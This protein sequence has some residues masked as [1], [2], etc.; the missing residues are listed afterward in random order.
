MF[1]LKSVIRRTPLHRCVQSFQNQQS[2][3]PSYLIDPEEVR[4]PVP[5]GEIA[6]KWWG[7]RDFRPVLA[8]HGWLDNAGTFDTLIPLLPQHASFLAIDL[9]GH[10][11]SSRI[12]AGLSYQSMDHVYLIKRIVKH[13]GWERVSLLGHSMGSIISMVYAATFPGQVDL[14]IGLDCLK[15][16]IT[17][18][19][20]IVRR[21]EDRIPKGLLAD[22]RNR[23]QAEPPSY[24]Y[25]E[26][27]E[28][29]HQGSNRSVSK[30]VAPYLLNRNIAESS[31][32]P[33]RFFFTRDSRL[34]FMHS[35]SVGWSQEMC[36]AMAKRMAT[37]PYLFLKATDSPYYEDKKYFDQF[38]DVVRGVNPLFR[39][40]YVE[41]GH[42]VHLS[43]A[44]KVA[45][46][47]SSFLEQ[48][49]QRGSQSVVN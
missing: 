23:D 42:H 13:Y 41:G 43:E 44:N 14:Y 36:L 28:R 21:L 47:V 1:S 30:E 15:S 4:I 32:Q 16:H 35:V 22:E 33:G 8:I 49:W 25:E 40:E 7:P 2:I 27:V 48:Y 20:E 34:K 12:P 6:G 17:E 9:P 3:E 11:L 39:L 45:P 19:A 46:I 29:L 31:T 10:G 26:L 24:T 38:V 37:M 5:F 18:P